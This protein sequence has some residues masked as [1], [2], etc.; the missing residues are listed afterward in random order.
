[1]PTATQPFERDWAFRSSG[2]V[3]PAVEKSTVNTPTFSRTQ[4]ASDASGMYQLSAQ[5]QNDDSMYMRP[6]PPRV[7]SPASMATSAPGYSR[8]S[9]GYYGSG[10]SSGVMQHPAPFVDSVGYME[11]P[12]TTTTVP[13]SKHHFTGVEKPVSPPSLVKSNAG[14]PVA[15]VPAKERRQSPP[16]SSA[17]HHHPRRRSKDY[18][19]TLNN[20]VGPLIGGGKT[21]PPAVKR[22]M[23]DIDDIIGGSG[24]R[25][26]CATIDDLIERK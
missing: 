25:K 17:V 16:V 6:V 10:A 3:A 9:V 13:D 23:D 2:I 11:K 5:Y 24:G 4:S 19:Y 7:S 8:Y 18:S 14:F 26:V 15:A 12:L 22:N 21:S 20:A 1:M